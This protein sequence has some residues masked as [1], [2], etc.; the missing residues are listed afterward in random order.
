MTIHSPGCRGGPPRRPRGQR[1]PGH[2]QIPLG[3]GGQLAAL[4]VAKG[5]G[6]V[7]EHRQRLIR[8][9]GH[10]ADERLRAG[11]GAGVGGDGQRHTAGGPDLLGHCVGW[12]GVGPAAADVDTGVVD[13]HGVP[14]L[15]KGQGDGQADAPATAGDDADPSTRHPPTVG[16]PVPSRRV[17]EKPVVHV[18]VAPLDVPALAHSRLLGSLA[19]A[20]RMRAGRY[21]DPDDARRFSAARGWLRQVL[22]TELETSP[23]DVAFA[24]AAAGGKPRLAGGGVRF[25][26]SHA[27]EL[28]VIAV[29][30]F[31]V[32]VDVEHLDRGLRIREAASVACTPEEI[33]TLD[34]LPPGPRAGAF[35][36]M[37]TAKEAYLK[38]TGQGLSVPPD[39]V[40]FG[41][42][43]P[44]GAMPVRMVDDAA[45]SRWWVRD[46]R[47][48]P[49]YV[50]AVAAVGR[51]WSVELRA[52][53][54]LGL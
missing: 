7:D 43:D 26:L 24:A 27:G 36:R 44:G 39:R 12:A 2:P 31:E 46:L 33:A 22:A 21:L 37:W 23:A 47:P 49:G 35:L 10:A 40:M 53:D 29:A 50:G 34:L 51:D 38:A 13:A 9:F 48:A 54:A 16:G 6:G 3:A 52:A 4:P 42:A 30:P 11:A 25:N 5:P 32:G 15:G 8:P 28:A 18:W 14:G 17:P 19:P 20:E 41:P 1:G 45:P